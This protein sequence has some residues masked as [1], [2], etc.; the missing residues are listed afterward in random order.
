MEGSYV[1]IG[2]EILKKVDFS[3][4]LSISINGSIILPVTLTKK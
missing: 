1:E 4:V 2:D 3:P